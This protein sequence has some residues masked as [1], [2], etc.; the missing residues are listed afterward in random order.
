MTA[1][2]AGVIFCLFAKK[3]QSMVFPFTV[4]TISGIKNL[5]QEQNDPHI[6]W[7]TENHF[8]Q[9]FGGA[10]KIL[11]FKCFYVAKDCRIF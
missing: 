5:V 8:R 2:I 1:M 11:I 3:L 4:N 10:C 7:V 6:M 9:I